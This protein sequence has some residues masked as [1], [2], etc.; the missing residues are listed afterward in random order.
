MNLRLNY[1]KFPT[2]LEGFSK[3]DWNTFSDDS[4]AT[5]GYIFS[6]TGGAVSWKSKKRTILAQSTMESEIIALALASEEAG[7]LRNLISD[8][9]LWKRPIPIVLIHCNSTEAIAKVQNRYFN[10]KR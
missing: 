9:L 7:W 2:V 10:G 8:I 3:V 6:I 5:S 4:K 1:Q